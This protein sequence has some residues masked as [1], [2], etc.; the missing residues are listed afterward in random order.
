MITAGAATNKTLIGRAQTVNFKKGITSTYECQCPCPA[1]YSNA[2]LVP[3]SVAGVPG[4]T[5]QFFAQQQN[6]NC[7]G[8][9]TE[10]FDVGAKFSSDNPSVATINASGLGTAVAPGT[11]NIRASWSA[12]IVSY[13]G[14]PLHCE[15]FDT[16]ADCSAF[17][18]VTD[19]T[20]AN[21]KDTEG[22]RPTGIIAGLNGA[23]PAITVAET[24]A[25]IAIIT[26]PPT[27]GL[28]VS[29]SVVANQANAY[30][31]G[32]HVNHTGARPVGTLSNASGTTDQNG[33]FST[34]Y[35]SPP[36]GGGVIIRATMNS[37]TKE[38]YLV[39][40]IVGLQQL[41]AGNEYVLTG[42]TATHPGDFNHYGTAIA[43]AN[44][45][46]ICNDYEALYPGSTNPEIN[47]MSLPFGGKFDLGN[48]WSNAGVIAH[49]FEVLN[50]KIL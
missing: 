5:Q 41:Q 13:E 15:S 27:A 50:H 24:R 45:P 31:A 35:T 4:D 14:D 11:T 40:Y 48:N 43:V 39:V 23:D 21:D 6:M 29:L 19:F 9:L 49:D 32:G 44:L 47:D 7:L 2:R 25:N 46:L 3:S 36:F 37:M 20:L 18:Q 38:S 28:S 17:C 22:V 16:T 26:N 33:R 12:S 42:G 34:V 8:N 30:L 10:W 1:T